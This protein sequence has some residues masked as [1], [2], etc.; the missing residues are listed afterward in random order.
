MTGTPKSARQRRRRDEFRSAFTGVSD[1]PN[2]AVA[3]SR[4][5]IAASVPRGMRR[6]PSQRAFLRALKEAP[7]VLALRS[8]GYSNL[9]RVANDIA[10]HADWTTMCS[11]PTRAGIVER[12]GLHVDT[13]KRWVRW[14]RVRGWLGTVEEG[15]TVR[16]RKGTRAGLDDDGYGNRAAVWVLCVPRQT[17]PPPH[18]HHPADQPEDT[19]APPTVSPH[20]GETT[21]PSHARET[22]TPTR[23]HSR[24]SPTWG[25]HHTPRTKRDRLAACERLRHEATP[26]RRMT[27]WYLR[28]LLKPFLDAGWTVADVLHALDVRPD[29]SRWTYTWLSSSELRH[30]PGWVRYRLAAWI[31]ADGQVLA[32]RSQRKAAAD[33]RVRASQQA[34]RDE[35]HAIAAAAGT[36]LPRAPRPSRAEALAPPLSPATEPVAANA[37]FRAARAELERRRRERAVAAAK[38]AR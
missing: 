16:F 34:W 20:R 8:D 14:L 36:E 21:D 18:D 11:R 33:A 37:A 13:V 2:L 6:S 7:E 12:T 27:G 15:T 4:A 32:S 26:F 29:D 23:T 10:F 19:T 35:L 28:H 38:P 31:D 25:L 24:I 30:V 17:T 9:L 5:L 1:I 22:P 3:P